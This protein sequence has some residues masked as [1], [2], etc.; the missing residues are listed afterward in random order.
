MR[1]I[2]TFG[3]LRQK[4]SYPHDAALMVVPLSVPLDHIFQLRGRDFS[5]STYVYGTYV[6]GAYVD[7]QF[8]PAVPKCQDHAVAEAVEA[9]LV[10]FRKSGDWEGAL[11]VSPD[12]H[13]HPPITVETIMTSINHWFQA[14]GSDHVCR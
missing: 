5:C 9:E 1:V 11:Q 7:A 14:L 4:A 8:R 2:R 13:L 3:Q 6:H 12:F 10:P